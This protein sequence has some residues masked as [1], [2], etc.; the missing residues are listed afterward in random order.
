MY[1][2]WETRYAHIVEKL[3]IIEIFI[4]RNAIFLKDQVIAERIFISNLLK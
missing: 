2:M 1:P 4:L 3:S